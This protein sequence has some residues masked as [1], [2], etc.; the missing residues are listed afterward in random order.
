[1]GGE[2]GQV[3]AGIG[4]AL[5]ALVAGHEDRIEM[6]RTRMRQF[7]EHPHLGHAPM[8]GEP[9]PTPPPG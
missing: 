6:F 1:V 4:R 7:V 3:L 9:G 2:H 5:L 8:L